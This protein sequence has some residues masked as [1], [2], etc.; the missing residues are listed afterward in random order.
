MTEDLLNVLIDTKQF[1]LNTV[2]ISEHPNILKQRKQL[3]LDL[4]EMINYVCSQLS[5]EK[6]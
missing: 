5:N 6:Y 2:S 1:L 4:E 3:I